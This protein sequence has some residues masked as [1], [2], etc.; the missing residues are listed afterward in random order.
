MPKRTRSEDEEKV[1]ATL[2]ERWNSDML[3]SISELLLDSSTE[4]VVSAV[5]SE[6]TISRCNPHPRS[7]RAVSYSAREF[8]E[9]RV[10]GCGLQGCAG[11]IRRLCSYRYYHDLD[12]VNCSP[13]LLFQII[14]KA[15]GSCSILI[16]DYA[17]DRPAMFKRMREQEPELV[18][19]SDKALKGM[20]LK[21][22]HGGDHT[23]YFP[24][25]GL[26]PDHK[27]IQLLVEWEK[28]LRKVMKRLMKHDDFKHLAKQ[29]KKMKDKPNKVGTFTSW[30]WQREENK[31]IL[32]L[33]NYLQEK[34]KLKPGVLVFDGIMVERQEGSPPSAVLDVA[35]LRRMEEFVQKTTGLKVQFIEKPLTPS[36][37]DWDRFWGE[38]ALHKIKTDQGKQLYLL[39]RV[40]Q[41]QGY[42]RQGDWLMKPHDTIPG[43]FHQAEESTDFI[44]RVLK[45]YHLYR[46]ASMKYLQEWFSSV[47]HP[48]FELLTKAKMNTTVISFLNGYLD[49][50][51]LNFHPWT[52][53]E[54]PPLT[55]H[56]FEKELDLSI[57]MN[58][59]TPLW[60]NLLATQI[61][62]RPTCHKCEKGAAYIQGEVLACE[63]HRSEEAKLAPLSMFDMLEFL[64]VVCFTLW[65]GTTTGR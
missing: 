20:F 2:Y 50:E 33:N 26:L 54:N 62:G 9:G 23:N 15:R 16:R 64:L 59:P 49:L 39:A 46:G 18:G 45:P 56:F 11:W 8:E 29:I 6:M 35:I 5:A 42:K 32:A 41:T 24:S 58:A 22:L 37:A 40:G 19:V 48:K 10:Y 52:D 4:A 1:A 28:T 65:A 25:I 61:G 53:V 14:E 17:L 27:P 3:L 21:S 51:S 57:G 63:H 34:E 60:D 43:V 31:I 47:D 55:D 44:N 12:I 13:T 36:L 38:K 7:R 30:V